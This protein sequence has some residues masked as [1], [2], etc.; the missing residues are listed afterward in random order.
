MIRLL[1]LLTICAST[2]QAQMADVYCY[3]PENGEITILSKGLKATMYISNK[4]G[5]TKKL[6][7]NK[8]NV[9]S[10]KRR[11]KKKA[12]KLGEKFGLLEEQI[13]SITKYSN[14]KT[15]VFS[16]DVGQAYPFVI[17]QKRNSTQK[18]VNY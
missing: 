12:I 17:L 6:E 15:S 8:I 16:F 4:R 3:L 11:E 18:C 10:Q 13:Y 9:F 2:V 1:L 14:R 7:V 5:K